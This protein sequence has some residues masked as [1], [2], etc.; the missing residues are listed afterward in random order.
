M[1]LQVGLTSTANSPD[2]TSPILSALS[3][4]FVLPL[5]SFLSALTPINSYFVHSTGV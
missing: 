5:T 1:N 3:I 2:S 4:S